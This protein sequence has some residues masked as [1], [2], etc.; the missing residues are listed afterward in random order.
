MTDLRASEA[1][2]HNNGTK[3]IN[4]YMASSGTAK[5]QI[6]VDNGTVYQDIPDTS[7][8]ASATFNITIPDCLIKAVITG[9]S[10]VTSNG[11]S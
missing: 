7:K 8:T 11:V 2:P 1:V 3:N 10:V 4:M 5:L 6:S 9:D